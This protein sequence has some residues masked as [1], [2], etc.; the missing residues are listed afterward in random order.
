MN[1][2][3]A[4][5]TRH[6]RSSVARDD[7]TRWQAVYNRDRRSDG[8][9]VFAVRTTGVY[10]RP[11]CASRRPR[12]ENVC[13]FATPSDAERVGFRPCKR[14]RP[15]ET[16][17]PDV[18]IARQI[19]RFV[20]D[21]PDDDVTLTALGAHVGLS[22]AHVQR[23]F[24]AV[25]GVTPR[26]YVAARRADR[27]KDQLRGGES[28][29]TAMYD[30]GYRSVSQFYEQAPA[31]LGMTPTA[32]RKGGAGM[33]IAYAT[34]SSPLGHIL[35]AATTRG[36]CS[37]RFGESAAELEAACRR[38]FPAAAVRRD[39]A[40]LG[41]WVDAV[42]AYL[43]GRQASL[44]LPV[45]VRATAFQARVWQ[46]LLAIPCGSTRSYGDVAAAIGQP[47]AVRAV[48]RACAENPV[49]LIIPCHRVVR[50]SGEPG[51]YRWGAERKR[52]LLEREA[53]AVASGAAREGGAPRPDVATAVS[54]TA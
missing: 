25:V 1:V 3:T 44:D 18:A 14:C 52:A 37:V 9:F 48:A 19:C 28:V 20:E 33:A 7:D 35:V 26:Q 16:M 4:R 12:R 21:H 54:G 34:A 31:R 41:P 36:V 29:T 30:A 24:K 10:C 15:Q 23:V 11:S 5:T 27:V 39:D 6:E 42:V 38:E 49:P 50:R 17:A 53:R 13:F 45:D 40:S 8:S 47:A 2:E 46:A 43:D 32:Y 22:P 51:G